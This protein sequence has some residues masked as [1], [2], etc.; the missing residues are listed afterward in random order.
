MHIIFI[1]L[2]EY[3]LPTEDI[4]DLE[5]IKNKFEEIEEYD[6]KDITNKYNLKNSIV[7]LIFKN[8]KDVRILYRITIKDKTNLGLVYMVFYNIFKIEYRDKG[9][10]S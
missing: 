4:E 8:K 1:Y 6:F 10:I 9:F 2:I 5:L 7:T 3:I